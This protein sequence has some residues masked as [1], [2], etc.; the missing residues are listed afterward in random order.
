MD[1]MLIMLLIV[2]GTVSTASCSIGLQCLN[3]TDD[4]KNSSNHGYL[5]VMLFLSIASILAGF[6]GV[7][8]N[9]MQSKKTVPVNAS[10]LK[11]ALK[12]A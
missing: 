4:G 12:S 10:V 1:Y 7:A 2:L 8:Y 5:S 9:V 11:N 3:K 6:A